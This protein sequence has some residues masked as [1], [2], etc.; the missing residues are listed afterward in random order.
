MNEQR[1]L[2][3]TI[4]FEDESMASLFNDGGDG[5]DALAPGSRA[6]MARVLLSLV[7]GLMGQQPPS[8]QAL[9]VTFPFVSHSDIQVERDRLCDLTGQSNRHLFGG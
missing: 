8:V 7:I 2:Y 5:F 3:A 9:Q 1:I 6:L 4:I